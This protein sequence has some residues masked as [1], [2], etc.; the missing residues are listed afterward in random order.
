MSTS[1]QIIA[2]F[3][4]EVAL[5]LKLQHIKILLKDGSPELGPALHSVHVK[6]YKGK[7]RHTK[8]K[9]MHSFLLSLVVTSDAVW[10]QN[11]SKL[12]Y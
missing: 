10:Q 8:C 2:G 9:G 4:Q 1:S 12:E 3:H 11:D 6:E 7:T 5:K